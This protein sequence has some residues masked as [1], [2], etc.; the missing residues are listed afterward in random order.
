MSTE[1]T[2]LDLL[3]Q[4]DSITDANRVREDL[5]NLGRGYPN[6]IGSKLSYELAEQKL[7]I[8]NR[9][10][11][12]NRVSDLYARW[13][14]DAIYLQPKRLSI[15]IGVNDAWRIMDKLPTGAADR[16]ESSYRH[17]LAITKEYLPQAGLILCEPFVLNVG[18]P[19]NNWDGWKAQ[20][21][22]YQEVTRGLA[23]EYGAVFVPL[24]QRFDEACTRAEA[25]FWARDGVHPTA[26][27]HQLIANAW[28]DA[29]QN[30][31]LAIK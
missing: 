28:L 16:F 9:G 17:L 29:V 5:V 7:Q 6:L 21:G 3:F 15:L 30:S 14:E 24:Q 23:K 25:A 18:V 11:S 2:P 27:G 4:G 12:G 26:A 19:A 13:N 31:P 8:Q 20:V 10:I 22:K 1:Q